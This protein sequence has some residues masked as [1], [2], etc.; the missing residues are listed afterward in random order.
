MTVNAGAGY[1]YALSNDASGR[2]AINASTGV[3]TVANNLLIDYERSTSHD[4]EVEATDSNGIASY[5]TFTIDVD[6]VDEPFEIELV[7]SAGDT[8]TFAVK[9]VD[10]AVLALGDTLETIDARVKFDPAQLTVDPSSVETI[11]GTNSS[12]FQSDLLKSAGSTEFNRLS[13]SDI[14]V[15]APTVDLTTDALFTFD[16]T[17]KGS[18]EVIGLSVLSS[19]TAVTIGDTE[20]TFDTSST[21]TFT[22]S[23]SS[24]TG[25]AST[26]MTEKA[27]DGTGTDEYSSKFFPMLEGLLFESPQE[28]GIFIRA[29]KLGVDGTN[30]FEIV[31]TPDA[32]TDAFDFKLTGSNPVYDFE[33]TDALSDFTATGMELLSRST[34]EIVSLAANTIEDPIAAGDELVIAT[35]KMDGVGTIDVTR[36]KINDDSQA[37]FQASL[38][39]IVDNDATGFTADVSESG[40]SQIAAIADYP[41]LT[42]ED[43]SP[44]SSRDALAVLKVAVGVTTEATYGQLIAADYDGSGSISSRDALG[45]LKYVVGIDNA[46]APEWIFVDKSLNL[47]ETVDL[48]QEDENFLTAVDKV[49]YSNVIDVG[50]S[51]NLQFDGIL[52]GDWDG[53]I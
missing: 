45:I 3:V 8:L 31:L 12:L 11:I 7:A 1:S 17:L 38:T 37:N 16:A 13:V 10:D 35:F 46:K 28:S 9:L 52:L 39:S 4:I 50:L 40:M 26:L 21:N 33:L 44:H 25:S 18:P 5:A 22:F 34:D 15:S 42:D 24:V 30:E 2:F 47:G 32:E 51:N 36:A 43:S 29:T 48:T 19:R 27:F 49:S 14:A 41:T 53:G 6:D 23:K 20:S